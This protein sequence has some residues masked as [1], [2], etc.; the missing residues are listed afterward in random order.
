MPGK[1]EKKGLGKRQKTRKTLIIVSFILM[2]VTFYYLSPALIIQGASEGVITGSFIVF[3]LLFLSS[4]LFGRAFCGWVCPAGGGQEACF[5][6]RGKRAPGGRLNWIKYFIWAPWLGLIVAMFLK[7]GGVKKVDPLYQT[8]HGISTAEMPAVIALVVV[9]V[10]ILGIALATGKRGFCHYGCWMAPFM[11]IGRKLRNAGGWKSLQLVP[12]HAK[13]TDCKKCEKVCPMSL[14]VN[15][16]VA[17][18][19]ME[20]SECILCGMCVDNCP[21]QAIALS[22]TTRRNVSAARKVR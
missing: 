4:L 6:I 22:F 1:Q 11:I 15:A 13:C 14:E 5:A 8:W 2:P 18:E 16:M 21:R 10:V 3:G 17:R 20:D 12:E 7:A 9:L 19:N